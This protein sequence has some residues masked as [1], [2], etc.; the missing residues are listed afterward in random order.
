[1]IHLIK[2]KIIGPRKVYT[3]TMTFSFFLRQ[4]K[5]TSCQPIFTYKVLK[6]SQYGIKYP[7]LTEKVLDHIGESTQ[8]TIIHRRAPDIQIPD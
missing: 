3:F 4:C 1:M 8:H 7:L 5:I 6:L 2:K